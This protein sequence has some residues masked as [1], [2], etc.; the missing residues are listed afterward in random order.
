MTRINLVHPSELTNEHLLAEYREIM[1]LPGNLKKSLNRKY[2]KFTVNEIPKRYTLGKGHVKFF[3]DKLQFVNCRFD[4]LVE[5][6]RKR[7]YDPKFAGTPIFKNCPEEFYNRFTPLP[8]EIE[9]NR[10]RIRE[11]L[12]SK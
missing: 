9:L 4:Q 10:D 1:R 11:R 6:L 8:E 5:E 3:Y 7:G 12:T 2:K